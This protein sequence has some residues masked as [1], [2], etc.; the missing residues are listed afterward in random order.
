[1]LICFVQP[2]AAGRASGS[3]GEW[4]NDIGPD[5]MYPE[6]KTTECG[7]NHFWKHGRL[8]D[9]IDDTPRRWCSAAHIAEFVCVCIWVLSDAGKH[10][11]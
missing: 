10:I 3:C 4:I 8:L 5:R 11:C 6:I 7:G 2:R 9:P 1:M